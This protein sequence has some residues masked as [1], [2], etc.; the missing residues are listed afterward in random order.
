M[1][2]QFWNPIFCFYIFSPSLK[3]CASLTFKFVC[4]VPPWFLKIWLINL[5]S[6]LFKHGIFKYI[7]SN[8][9]SWKFEPN[10]TL[11]VK[12]VQLL[13]DMQLLRDREYA[14]ARASIFFFFLSFACLIFALSDSKLLSHLFLKF[15][16]GETWALRCCQHLTC[17]YPFLEMTGEL[18]SCLHWAVNPSAQL[19]WLKRFRQTILEDLFLWSFQMKE[20]FTSGALRNQ[21]SWVLNYFPRYVVSCDKSFVCTL[22]TNNPIP[23]TII[24]M[25]HLLSFLFLNSFSFYTSAFVI[26]FLHKVLFSCSNVTPL[27]LAA[28][29]LRWRMSF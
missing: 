11:E 2:F 9:S 7:L 26:S 27:I 15:W 18:R 4:K 19:L 29:F 17:G 5:G 24:Y 13:S 14:T 21:S 23:V 20:K 16:T 28:L 1:K 22:R 10:T 8:Y 6:G 25:L 12:T 3:S